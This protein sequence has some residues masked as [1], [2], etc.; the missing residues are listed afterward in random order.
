MAIDAQNQDDEIEIDDVAT[1]AKEIGKAVGVDNAGKEDDAP[2][3]E[4]EEGDEVEDRRVARERGESSDGQ[5]SF[6]KQ[7]AKEKR[8]AR[9]RLVSRRIGEKDQTISQ[10]QEQLFAASSKLNEFESRFSSL[11]KDKVDNAIINNKNIIAQADA[12]YKKAFA[13][14]DGDASSVALEKKY[15]AK[16]RLNQLEHWKQNNAKVV[17]TPNNPNAVPSA[18][19]I[20]KA[21]AWA[22]KHKDWYDPNGK[23]EDTAIARSLSGVLA[24]EG[25]DPTTDKFWK[26]LDKRLIKKGVIDQDELDDIDNDDDELDELDDK[27]APKAKKRPVPPS[28]GGNSNRGDFG[29]KIKIK[30]PTHYVNTLKANGIW[31]DVPTRNKVIKGYLENRKN[32]SS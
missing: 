25:F 12:D 23:D 10:L 30:L 16:G 21:K 20:S 17:T 27:P 14:G 7:S 11:D 24:D 13:E 15:E 6:K 26:E 2:D 8:D 19:V 3:Y 31:D 28:G 5:R 32:L 1:K 4:I 9:K 18:H 22:N 29:N